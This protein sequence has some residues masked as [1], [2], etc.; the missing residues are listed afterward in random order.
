M[1]NHLVSL[2]ATYAHGKSCQQLI[3]EVGR[4]EGEQLGGSMPMWLSILSPQVSARW[5]MGLDLLWIH[6]HQKENLSKDVEINAVYFSNDV[7]VG[8]IKQLLIIAI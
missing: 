5:A 2:G 1:G 7:K 6:T 3:K 4:S 8:C